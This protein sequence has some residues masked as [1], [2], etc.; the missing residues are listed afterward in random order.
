MLS[1]RNIMQFFFLKIIQ[2]SESQHSHR[3]NITIMINVCMHYF[4]IHV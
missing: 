3:S 2:Q 4:F 1:I